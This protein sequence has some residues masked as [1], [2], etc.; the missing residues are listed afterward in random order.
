MD[1]RQQGDNNDII[2][3]PRPLLSIRPTNLINLYQLAPHLALTAK[4]KF[5][6]YIYIEGFH[7]SIFKFWVALKEEIG[8]CP[9]KDIKGVIV[10]GKIWELVV[11]IIPP[12]KQLVVLVFGEI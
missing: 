5:N 10:Q 6:Y 7:F 12:K 2:N 4:T 3:T 11:L 8:N 1:V 9:F